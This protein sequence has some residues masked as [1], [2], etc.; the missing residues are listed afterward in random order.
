MCPENFKFSIE[1]KNYKTPP[2]FQS[3]IGKDVTPWNSWLSQAEQ[4]AVNSGKNLLLIVKYNNVSEFIFVKEKL[5]IE[6][7][8]AYK[9]Y[10]L[11]TLSEFLTLSNEYFFKA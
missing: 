7:V 8:M 2:S 1:C 9:G 5:E 10:F 6:E 4:D 3:I 11:Y